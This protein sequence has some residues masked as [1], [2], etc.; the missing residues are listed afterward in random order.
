MSQGN[1]LC[2]EM[3][4]I[5]DSLDLLLTSI[6]NK[7]KINNMFSLSDVRDGKDTQDFTD[8]PP[9]SQ[10]HFTDWLNNTV[11]KTITEVSQPQ[12]ILKQGAKK[13]YMDH[14]QASISIPFLSVE[15]GQF[16]VNQFDEA[17]D[18]TYS[19]RDISYDR[20]LSYD[21][22]NLE[23]QT[24]SLARSDDTILLLKELEEAANNYSFRGIRSNTALTEGTTFEEQTASSPV[25]QVTQHLDRNTTTV[26]TNLNNVE[27]NVHTKDATTQTINCIIE[28]SRVSV[29]NSKKRKRTLHLSLVVN[30]YSD[31]ENETIIATHVPAKRRKKITYRAI[32]PKK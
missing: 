15:D 18:V 5:E 20:E 8:Q 26:Q 24:S 21:E 4:G 32:L 30:G 7:E 13:I 9:G 12:E 6:E 28:S 1:I 27:K 29:S 22:P 10:T 2:L 23:H 11:A 31:S 3:E 14:N 17:S 25:Q 16:L 19:F